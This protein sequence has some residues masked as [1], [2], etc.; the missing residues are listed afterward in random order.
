MAVSLNVLASLGSVLGGDNVKF[1]LGRST[2]VRQDGKEYL[3]TLRLSADMSDRDLALVDGYIDHECAHVRFTDFPLFFS[4]EPVL[5]RLTNA[6]EDIRIEGLMGLRYPGSKINLQRTV[7]VL[8]EDNKFW[9]FPER[10]DKLLSL[11]SK[12]ALYVGRVAFLEQVPLKTRAEKTAKILLERVGPNRFNQIKQ[13]V[14]SMGSMQSTTDAV[15]IASE[16]LDLV[17]EMKNAGE[18][19]PKPQP[20]KSPKQQKDDDS[21]SGDQSGDDDGDSD[22]D[23]GD[24]SGDDDGDSDSDSGEQSGDDDGDSDSD[25]GDQSGDDDGEDCGSGFNEN[26]DSDSDYD[27][28]EDETAI[29]NGLSD[30]NE[31][32]DKIASE[33]DF[34]T[35]MENPDGFD[36]FGRIIP[37]NYRKDCPLSLPSEFAD[38]QITQSCTSSF[39]RWARDLTF[40]SRTHRSRGNN[41][42]QSRLWRVN[43]GATRVFQHD[44]RGIAPSAAVLV[45]LDDSGSMNELVKTTTTPYRSRFHYARMAAASLNDALDMKDFAVSVLSY[46]GNVS[47]VSDWESNVMQ[48]GSPRGGTYAD[49]AIATAIPHIL[50]RKEERKIIMLLTDGDFNSEFIPA[51]LE[52][53]QSYGIDFCAVRFGDAGDTL[54]GLDERLN[55]FCADMT[56]LPEVMSQVICDC[57]TTD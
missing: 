48:F 11:V 28:T 7:S 12:F 57:L 6:V 35:H 23:S 14:L 38:D 37:I 27:D 26:G 19:K 22:S 2:G 16:L 1:Q 17:N 9:S 13:I 21:D 44:T 5:R 47:M 46:N 29:P 20:K 24:Q 42:D 10:D 54:W 55:P 33:K 32:I 30:L 25:S 53:M 4:L 31:V 40:S 18:G 39:Q 45:L 49:T 36:V 34:Q 52:E 8:C 56:E 41:I 3:V 51:A 15:L 50:K 43:A